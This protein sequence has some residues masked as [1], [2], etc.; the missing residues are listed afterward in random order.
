MF[1]TIKY[2]KIYKNTLKYIKL[3]IKPRK[4][5]STTKYVGD[6]LKS[7]QKMGKRCR[8]VSNGSQ[9]DKYELLTLLAI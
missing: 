2:T 8:N 1:K 3:N 7:K 4:S 6:K 9:D 5:W